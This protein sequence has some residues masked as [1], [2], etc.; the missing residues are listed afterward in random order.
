MVLASFF[1]W[2]FRPINR[3]SMIDFWIK[4]HNNLREIS[5]HPLTM[6]V[7]LSMALSSCARSGCMLSSAA[8]GTCLTS[9]PK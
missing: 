3:F 4:F 2:L 1:L 7:L 6:M 5:T 8:R 9:I